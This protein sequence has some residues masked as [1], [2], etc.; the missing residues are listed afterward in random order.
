MNHSTKPTW[1]HMTPLGVW[2]QGSSPLCPL[3]IPVSVLRESKNPCKDNQNLQLNRHFKYSVR[4]SGDASG[5]VVLETRQCNQE[6]L[7]ILLFPHYLTLE[8]PT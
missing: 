7:G 1:G 6:T 8:E 2:G 5:W 4:V 3:D